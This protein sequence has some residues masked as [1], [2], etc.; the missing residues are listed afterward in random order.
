MCFHSILRLIKTA[1]LLGAVFVS[2]VAVAQS[3]V[4][5]QLFDQD[6]EA[7]LFSA[8]VKAV[9]PIVSANAAQSAE[10]GL[11]AAA[12]P[13]NNDKKKKLTKA[14]KSA[15]K[16]LFYANDFSYLDDPE[17]AGPFFLG[18][19]LKRLDYGRLDIGGEYRLRYHNEHNHRGLGLTGND[20][21]FLL[22]R[23]RL[24]ANYRINDRI[25]FYGEYLYADSGGEDFN[26]RPIEENRGEAQNL[27]FDVKLLDDCCG[28]LT[29]RVGR[30]ELL[31]GAQRL[32]SPLDWANTRRTFDGYR[33]T[34]KT[35]DVA[36]DSFYTNPVAR[37][38]ATGGNHEWDRADTGQHFF[39]TYLT[40]QLGDGHTTDL[41]YIALDNETLDFSFH[42]IG[43][44]LVG[45]RGRL[46]YELEGGVQF[47]EDS[48]GS[49][50]GAGFV[51]AGIGR[52][53]DFCVAGRQRQPT[54]WAWYDWA[55][56]GDAGLI[57][58][59]DNGFHH[60]FPLAHK[61]NGFLD[62]FGRRNLND[63]NVQ[64]I[65]PITERVKLIL[66]YHYFFLD[67]A[68]TPYSVVMTPFN[69]A[70]PAGDKEL[71]HEIDLLLNVTLS[72]RHSCLV[73]YSFF[74]AGDYYDTTAGV[75]TNS[76]ANFLYLQYQTRF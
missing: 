38:P 20:D 32:V 18:D 68:T 30:Q 11:P 36:V 7:P 13:A 66:W 52:K 59:G 34:Y 49:G 64:L 3:P 24:F 58:P 71:G 39:G 51:T 21:E 17:F 22:R 67:Q 62:L 41:Y 56:G 5:V 69:A 40:R 53:L 45:N 19:S 65:S 35:A 1:V 2:G 25:R 14:A 6:V 26:P 43:S 72:P 10:V 76:D 57:S 23:L 27:F 60:F 37:V 8:P 16:G 28:S 54:I 63:V 9:P 48:D 73:G 61:Y 4:N 12:P 75:P 29:A 46:L 44:R 47:G 31:F 55:S 42:T 33:L 70:N 50:H 15:F 74:S